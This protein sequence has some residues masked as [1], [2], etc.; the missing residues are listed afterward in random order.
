[1]TTNESGF[2]PVGHNILVIPDLK[3]DVSPGGI[4][5]PEDYVSRNRQVQITGTVVGIG[6]ECWSDK[7]TRYCNVG[8][9]VMF[10][11]LKGFFVDGDD[12]IKYRMLQDLDIL[13][14][15]GVGN[16]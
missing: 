15:K 14:V 5:L 12:G 6:A 13:A 2:F 10:A 8:D 7:K 11:K 4:V 16:E 3:E 9:R 1:M